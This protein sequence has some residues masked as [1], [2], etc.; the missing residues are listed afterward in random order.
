MKIDLKKEILDLKKQPIKKEEGK[1]WTLS[2]FL[3]DVILGYK[4]ESGI[5]KFL[6]ATKIAEAKEFV[7]VDEA[8]LQ[9]IKEAVKS[10][11]GLFSIESL[12]SLFKGQV[13]LYL[14]KLIDDKNDK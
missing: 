12:N 1:I 5:K 14:S 9:I 8:D 10:S 6:L 2:D 7:E 11:E 3:P 4:G 13:E